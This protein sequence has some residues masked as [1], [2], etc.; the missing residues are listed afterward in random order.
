MGKRERYE[1]CPKT[2]DTRTE[3]KM[4][5]SHQILGIEG[6]HRKRG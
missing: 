5:R 2:T 1:D 4:F 3:G 6:T